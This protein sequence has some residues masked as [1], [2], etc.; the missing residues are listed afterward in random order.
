MEQGSTA[1]EVAA[2]APAGAG[3]EAQFL[4]AEELQMVDREVN[5]AAF[6]RLELVERFRLACGAPSAADGVRFRADSELG[7]RSLRA[8][9]ATMLSTTERTAEQLLQTAWALHERLP[10]TLR[11]FR[12]GSISERHAHV[13]VRHSVGLTAEQVVEL[14]KGALRVAERMNSARFDHRVRMLRQKITAEKAVERHRAA[15]EERHVAVEY[16]HD[17]MA[18]LTAY[19]PAVE[20]TA[21]L[22]RLEDTALGL[23]GAPEETR[24]RR[25]IM[26]DTLT[27]LLLGGDAPGASPIVPTVRLTVPV[28]TLLGQSDEPPVLDGFGPVDLETACRLTADAPSFT[29]VLTHPE[30]GAALSIGRTRYRPTTA[31]RDWLRMRDGTCRFPGCGRAADRCDLDHTTDWADGG[32]TD[33]LNLAHLCRAHHTL[34]HHTGWT[35]RPGPAPGDLE[36]TSPLGSTHLSEPEIRYGPPPPT[37]AFE[38]SPAGDAP[39]LERIGPDPLA[40]WYDSEWRRILNTYA[41]PFAP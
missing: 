2:M 20:A 40:D 4:L 31:M 8:E 36:W 16:T 15:A 5:I 17:Q 28:L 12:E 27:E 26:A 38:V 14:E 41:D 37:P 25:Q 23:R 30:T 13:M 19:L 9:V 33:H 10:G 35:V 18:Y 3:L 21:I 32:A 22:N 29:R 39:E 1:A 11:V 6:R 34:K 24:S 7:W